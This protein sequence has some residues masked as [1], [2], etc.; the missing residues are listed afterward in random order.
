MSAK[1]ILLIVVVAAALLIFFTTKGVN[2][3]LLMIGAIAAGL[4]GL[5]FW[6]GRI[7]IPQLIESIKEIFNA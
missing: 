5:L 4:L 6:T 1:I 2:R 3:I 7:S